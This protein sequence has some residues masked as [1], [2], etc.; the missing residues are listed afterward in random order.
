M[1]SD[2][3]YKAVGNHSMRDSFLYWLSHVKLSR[4]IFL[5]TLI[6]VI[7]PL[8]TH[9]YLSKVDGDNSDSD[10][11]R[12]RLKLE[13]FEDFTSLKAADLKLR[14]EEM[15]RIKGMYV[16]LL[17]M[18]IK[19]HACR[20]QSMY[21]LYAKVCTTKVCLLLTLLLWKVAEK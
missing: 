6:L 20:L 7:V 18:Q 2:T 8:I 9:Y 4:I 10:I 17:C 16:S 14:I 11:H 1:T 12:S 21:I 5:V 19:S 3:G 15:L 13:A